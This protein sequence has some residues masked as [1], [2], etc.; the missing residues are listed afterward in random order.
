MV[1]TITQPVEKMPYT[2]E[3]AISADVLY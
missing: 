2:L 1:A 3:A